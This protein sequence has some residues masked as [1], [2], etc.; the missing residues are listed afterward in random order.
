M[1]SWPVISLCLPPRPLYL[2]ARWRTGYAQVTGKKRERTAVDSDDEVIFLSVSATP[3]A[4]GAAATA[5]RA[6]TS[7]A[8]AAKQ[9]GGTKPIGDPTRGSSTSDVA[10][11]GRTSGSVRSATAP[12]GGRA[13]GASLSSTHGLSSSSSSSSSSSDPTRMFSESV[14]GSSS[15]SSTVAQSTSASLSSRG[16]RGASS[17]TPSWALAVHETAPPAT[18]SGISKKRS[19]MASVKNLGSKKKKEKVKSPPK[20]KKPSG[21]S[22]AVKSK[23]KGPTAAERTCPDISTEDRKELAQE[24]N[25]FIE[26]AVAA[27]AATRPKPKPDAAVSWHKEEIQ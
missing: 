2:P 15:S 9:T 4:P 27:L 8:T 14:R 19:S 24:G 25:K 13:S 10:T 16:G 12:A 21:G 6:N 17:G 18:A 5:K 7:L 3:A 23:R 20:P 1:F 22:K 11:G 26:S